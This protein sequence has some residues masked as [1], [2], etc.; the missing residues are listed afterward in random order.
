MKL[1]T[2]RDADYMSIYSKRKETQFL[3]NPK[4]DDSCENDK[5]SISSSYIPS[6][7]HSVTGIVVLVVDFNSQALNNLRYESPGDIKYCNL[8][9]YT[10]VCR[11]EK[12]LK[13][14]HLAAT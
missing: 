14:S 11:D 7:Y 2:F 3:A 9:T 6:G 1:V 5:W 13:L 8:R 10:A 12:I 4:L